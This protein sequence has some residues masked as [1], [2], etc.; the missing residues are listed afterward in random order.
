MK[1]SLWLSVLSLAFSIPAWSITVLQ[2]NLEQL[3][4]LSEKV[5]DGRCVDIQQETDARGRNVQKVTFDVIEMLKGEPSA[6]ITFRQIGLVDGGS[7][8]GG[9]VKIEGLDRDLPRYQLG[10]EA[11]VFLSAP[12]SSGLTTPVGLEQGKFAVVETDGAKTVVNG[13]GNR[14]LF[15]GADKSLK[16]KAMAVTSTDR[17]LIRTN[18]GALPYDTLV[19]F[20][21][22]LANP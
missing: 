16:M 15:I 19:S 11:V 1:R 10:E 2:L 5:F 14:G 9:G 6:Q 20:V 12:G 18:G 13:A 4:G 7:D 22:K 3:T 21:K 17:A 8:I